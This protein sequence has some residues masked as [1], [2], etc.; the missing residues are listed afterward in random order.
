MNE[1]GKCG[2][3]I[4]GERSLTNVDRTKNYI[5]ERNFRKSFHNSN[6]T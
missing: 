6:S 5:A 3:Q 2:V 4:T 1:V